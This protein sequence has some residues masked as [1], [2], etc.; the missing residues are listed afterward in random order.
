[1]S[2]FQKEDIVLV[3]AGGQSPVI[4]IIEEIT[5]TVV[6]MRALFP[7]AYMP[8]MSIGRFNAMMVKLQPSDRGRRYLPNGCILACIYH[9]A[10]EDVARLVTLE[11]LKRLDALDNDEIL[12]QLV[13]NMLLYNQRVR[14]K[15]TNADQ[16][17]AEELLLNLIDMLRTLQIRD[18][19]RHVLE[20]GDTSTAAICILRKAPTRSTSHIRSDLKAEEIAQIKAILEQQES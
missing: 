11:L 7:E 2:L 14:A 17:I 20:H 5:D 4:G 9:G 3:Q 12:K 6:E 8:L 19:T 1:M 18:V 13:C 10:G 15:D 16:P